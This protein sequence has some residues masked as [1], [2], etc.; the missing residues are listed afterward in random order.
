MSIRIN[1]RTVK[2]RPA[3]ASPLP[4]HRLISGEDMD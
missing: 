3:P 2:D 1:E 4:V